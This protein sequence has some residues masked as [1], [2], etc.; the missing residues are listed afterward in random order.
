MISLQLQCR[1]YKIQKTLKLLFRIKYGIWWEKYWHFL[2]THVSLSLRKN[3]KIVSLFFILNDDLQ[4]FLFPFASCLSRNNFSGNKYL[5]FSFF[6]LFPLPA[7]FYYWTF[8]K[9]FFHNQTFTSA[10]NKQPFVGELN[11]YFKSTFGL[12]G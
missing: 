10:E 12:I 1:S 8:P 9:Y 2:Q 11:R 5:L 7:T 4:F 6:Q 3:Y